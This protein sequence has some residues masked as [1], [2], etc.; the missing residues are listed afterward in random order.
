VIDKLTAALQTAVKDPEVKSRLGSLGA[1]PV[2]A[3]KARPEALRSHLKHEMET[4]NPLLIKAGVQP[5]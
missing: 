2:T 4:L 3:D 5:D 1:L